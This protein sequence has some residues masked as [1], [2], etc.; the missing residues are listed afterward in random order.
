MRT[1]FRGLLVRETLIFQ[2]PSGWA[3]FAPFTEYDDAEASLWLKAA[4]EAAFE[5]FPAPVR[6]EVPINATVP[7]MPEAQVPALLERF[8][9][10]PAVKVKVAEKGQFLDDDVA[11]VRRVRQLLPEAK[12]R[13]D[14]NAG[15][16]E[17]EAVTA[18]QQLS[19]FDLEYAEQPVPSINGLAKV[20]QRLSDQQIDVKIAADESVRKAADPLAVARAGAADL[21]VIKA[22]PLGGTRRA[23]QIVAEAGLPAV[24]SSALETSIGMQMGLGLAAALPQLPFACGLGTVSLLDGD[25]CE[26]SLVAVDGHIQ[27]RDVEPSTSLLRRH[28]APEPR[29]SWWMERMRR[30]WDL[31]DSTHV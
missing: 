2:G 31:L 11:R 22:A 14:A 26:D 23:L 17:D 5:G 1:R 27:V 9:A 3:E 7:A 24:V 8:G 28:E 18:L 16:T 29:R 21:I 15:W 13:V 4:V 6:R 12:I 19:E 20:R 25:I 10:V 30:C